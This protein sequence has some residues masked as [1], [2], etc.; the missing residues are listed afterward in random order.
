MSRKVTPTLILLSVAVHL[1]REY[2][3]EGALL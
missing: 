2:V 3:H 1:S